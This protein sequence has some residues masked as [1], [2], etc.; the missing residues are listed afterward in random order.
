MKASSSHGKRPAA[1]GRVLAGL[2]RALAGLGGEPSG[3]G[4]VLAGLVWCLVIASACAAGSSTTGASAT[5]SAA[6]TAHAPASPLVLHPPSATP[7]A[8]APPQPISD[9]TQAVIA[10]PDGTITIELFTGSAPVATQ[11]FINLARAG[12]YNGVVFHRIVPGFVIQGG[13]GQ[14]GRV[15]AINRTLLGTGGPGYTFPD[16]PFAGSYTRGTV[17]M[18]NAGPN[19]NGSQFFIVLADAPQLPRA[20]T[21]FGRVV[22]G[23]SVVDRI[24]SGP[25]GGPQDDQALD[26]VPMLSVTIRRP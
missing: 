22:A 23:M 21:I 11:N 4:R 6:A 15:G 16:E 14:Y 24:A 19:T 18:A 5:S 3:L 20:Y 13:D 17:A 25:R 8:S 9:G 10:T 2:G 7:L 12:Y 26:P 1:P